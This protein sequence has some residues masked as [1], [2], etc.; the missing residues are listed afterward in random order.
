MLRFA[1]RFFGC[2]GAAVS[3]ELIRRVRSVLSN[4][5][6]FRGYGSSEGPV[7]TVGFLGS[8]N[9]DLAAETDG[10][11][12]D[13]DVRIV[14]GNGRD[15][16]SGSEGEICARGPALFV[17]TPILT[18]TAMLF[19]GE[20]YFHTGDVGYLTKDHAVVVTGRI[21]D[22]INRGGEKLSAKEIE[23]IL[24]THPGVQEAAVVSMPHARLGETV[25][26]YV[27]QRTGT[28]V[29]LGAI[30]ETMQ[31]ANVARQKFPEHLVVVTELPKTATGKLRKDLLRAD[32]RERI[33]RGNGKSLQQHQSRDT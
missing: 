9:I 1:L 18:R 11:V 24:Y 32:I 25:C 10:R 19:D 14:D 27:V 26:A 16:P 17:G 28:T 6:A 33:S 3:P 7:M 21:K 31:A 13:Y 12:V 15:V 4:C 30:I 2:G 22:L 8:K 29:T 5:S 20:G 23:D